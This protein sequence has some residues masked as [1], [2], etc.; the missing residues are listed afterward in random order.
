M[1]ESI[2]VID[3]CLFCKF[4]AGYGEVH[5][6]K[7]RKCSKW[8]KETSRLEHCEKYFKDNELIREMKKQAPSKM[9]YYER[10]K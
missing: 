6:Y 2:K 9:R 8:N 4:W 10:A 1:R 5:N 3:C 7:V